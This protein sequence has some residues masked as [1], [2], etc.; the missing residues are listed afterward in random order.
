MP[1]RHRRDPAAFAPPPAGAGRPRSAAPAWAEQPGTEVRRVQSDKA[2]RC[3]G[4][5]HPIRAGAPHL[6]VVPAGDPDARRHWH[7]ECWRRELRRR[8]TYRGGPD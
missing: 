4:C 8:G 7:T 6:V 1:R 3:P 5:D 2:Y